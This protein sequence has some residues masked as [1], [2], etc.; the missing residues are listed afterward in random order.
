MI[1]PDIF[2]N[3]SYPTSYHDHIAGFKVCSEV[4][5]EHMKAK[6]GGVIINM[7]SIYGMIGPDE[8]LYEGTNMSMP[9]EYAIVKGG[10]IAGT[11]WIAS[12][13][14]KYGVRAICVS[15]GG[16][17]DNQDGQFV[18]KYCDRVPLGYMA[19]PK[20]IASVV[21]ML[22]SDEAGYL[23]AQNIIIDG[24]LTGSI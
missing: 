7:A 2:I 8:R 10:I 21:V 24:G 4:V 3:C 12:M 5:A 13:Y 18:E 11:K 14:G 16:V 9:L 22:A 15:P 19:T 17:F 6:G 23:T 1:K 20:D